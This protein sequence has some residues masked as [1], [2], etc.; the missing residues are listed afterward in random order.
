M[1]PKAFCHKMGF[2]L[3]SEERP[4]GLHVIHVIDRD[5]R[6]YKSGKKEG[7]LPVKLQQLLSRLERGYDALMNLILEKVYQ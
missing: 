5:R 3:E 1:K 2:T 4:D 6:I 7:T